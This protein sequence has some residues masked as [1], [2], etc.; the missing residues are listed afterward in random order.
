MAFP[1]DDISVTD[2]SDLSNESAEVITPENFDGHVEIVLEDANLFDR[3]Q[4]RGVSRGDIS[5]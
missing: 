1:D 2:G 5:S 4:R 3:L